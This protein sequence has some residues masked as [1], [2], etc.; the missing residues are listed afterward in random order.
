MESDIG[1]Q[2][3]VYGTLGQKETA[4]RNGMANLWSLDINS[5]VFINPLG[6]PVK[7]ST[8]RIRVENT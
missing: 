4:H 3:L 5:I 1:L 7:I 6:K 8:T 2:N